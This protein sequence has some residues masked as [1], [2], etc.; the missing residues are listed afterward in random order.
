[1]Q[2]QSQQ[3]YSID[4]PP[5]NFGNRVF[6]GGNYR[7]GSLIDHIASAVSGCS[8]TPIV[9]AQFGIKRGTE[10]ESSLI[11]LRQCKFAIFEVTL[12]G[13]HIGEIE[14]ALDY[15][16]ITLCLW[17]ALRSDGPLMSAMVTSHPVF[18]SNNK[19]YKT[20]REMEEEVCKFLREG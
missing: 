6:V 7:F 13:G 4:S 2:V 11:L 12:D 17:D 10:R 16:T 20:I 5:G 9:A 8:F 19:G 3:K 15:N 18:N 14:R 1:M